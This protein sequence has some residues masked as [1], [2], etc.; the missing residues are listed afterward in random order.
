MSSTLDRKNLLWEG[1]RMF[2]PEHREALLRQREKQEDFIP[3]EL[4]EDQ[5]HEMNCIILEALHSDFPVLVKYVKNKRLHQSCGFIKKVHPDE[6][7]LKIANG[8]HEEIIPFS[9]VCGVE[10]E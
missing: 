3:P 9:A 6:H 8:H 1:S 10:K 7:W 2:L 5:L 4:D